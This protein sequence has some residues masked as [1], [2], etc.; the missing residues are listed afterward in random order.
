[1]K[2]RNV[3]ALAFLLAFTASM[4][5]QTLADYQFS[6]GHDASLWYTLTD[7]TDLLTNGNSVYSRSDLQSIGFDFPFADTSYSQFSVTHDGNLRLGS[8]LAISGSGNQASPFFAARAGNN[9]PKIN[10][11]G[12]AGYSSTGTHAYKQL[13]GTAPNRVMVVEFSL[14]TYTSSSRPALFVFQVQLHENG[15]IQV[16]YPSVAPSMMPSCNRQQGFCVDASDVWI[17]NQ[18]HEATHYTNGCSTY[19]GPGNWPDT[20]RYYRFEYPD[21]VCLSPSNLVAARVDTSSV[22]LAWNNPGFSTSFAVE[23]SAS[24]FA[25][26]TGAATMMVVNDT[27]AY[28]G[29]LQRDR[30]YHFYVRAICG[31]GDTSNAAYVLARTLQNVP[32]SDFP[33]YCDFED[34]EER[35]GWFTPAGNLATL[36][37]VDTAANNTAAGSY[38]LYISQDSGHTNTGGSQWIGAYAWRDV[39][40][41]AGD[42]MVGFDWRAAG[43]METSS[44]GNVNYYHF[45]RA[46]LVP[47]TVNFTIQTPASFPT[48][49][50]SSAVPAGWIELVPNH[51]LLGQTSWTRH[52]AAVNVPYAGCYHLTFYWETDGYPP[53]TDLP[54]AVDNIEM[55]YLSC[56]KPQGLT[57]TATEDEMMLRWQRV[58]SET[59][60][61]VRY[62]SNEVYVQD[63]FYLVTDLE[64]NTPYDFQVYTVCGEGD[65][66]QAATGTFR[67]ALGA[68][69]TQYPYVC[70]FEDSV[71]C[72]HWVMLDEGQQNQ[73]YCGTAAN[74]TLQGQR[75]IYVSNDGGTSNSYSGTSY[76]TSYA[77]REILLDV[78]TYVCSFDWRC[79]GDGEFHFLRAF[80]VPATSLP[81]SGSF[82]VSNNNYTAVPSGWTDLNPASHYMSEQSSWTTLTQSFDIAD[83]GLY[84]LLLMWFND[85]YT[86]HDPPAAVDN[87]MIDRITCPIP[88]NLSADAMQTAVDLTWDAGDDA[89]IWLVEYADTAL[90]TYT[91]SYTALGLSP[92]TEYTFSVSKLCMSGDTSLAATLTVRTKCEPMAMLPYF[93]D[94]EGY[95]VGTGSGDAFI[96]CWNRLC[97]YNSFS[98]RVDDGFTPGN[99]CL[100]FN[101]TVGLLDDVYVTLPELDESVEVTYTELSFKA[102]MFDYFGLYG[103]PVLIV[104]VMGDPMVASSFTPVD[105][106]VVGSDTGY[107]EYS[108]PMLSYVGSDQYV[109]IRATVWDEPNTPAV[110]LIDDV[111]LHELQYCRKPTAMTAL[112]GVDTIALSWT[113]G[114]D[115]TEWMVSYGDTM[116]T[117]QTSSYVARNLEADREYLFTV[118]AICSF[119]DTSDAITGH[120]RTL[121]RPQDPPDTVECLVPSGVGYYQETPWAYHSYEFHFYWSGDA[122]AYEVAIN[123]LNLPTDNELRFVVSDTTFF[124]DAHGRGAN[125][126]M[127]VRSLCS[128]AV[129]SGWSDTVEFDTPLCVR[130]ETP[131]TESGIA[132]YPNPSKGRSTLLLSGMEGMVDVRVVDLNGRLKGQYS[133]DCSSQSTRALLLD[134][135]ATGTYFVRI[136]GLDA[137]VVRKLVVR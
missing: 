91:P 69:V 34:G 71:E 125:W 99:H 28:I 32:V 39:N 55:E 113:A 72:R 87:I 52:Q 111:E 40:L 80:V 75:S 27:T 1:M 16:V 131:G 73:W 14:K 42:W 78:G 137:I 66:S 41:E 36:W 127:T 33:Y 93:D 30:Q 59:L 83:S 31:V 112:T 135:L 3:T 53:V 51:V 8:A 25:P 29:G 77:Y 62:G 122:P 48:S 85:N 38:A 102:R 11:F 12:C 128:D 103:E 22:T 92:N 37:Y 124:F 70:D 54:A 100:Y 45:L 18:N 2:T 4:H 132:L 19:I 64:F 43:D 97:N 123:C 49:P 46:F 86:P 114:G 60:W 7:S 126:T 129:S 115:E 117:T 95:A 17:V 90:M 50:H 79:Q 119:G 5:C 10:F 105:T 96:P 136:A 104:G 47:A 110:C 118:A 57:A 120:F 35:Q 121:P 88:A 134:G 89:Q 108:V 74:N 6:T 116:L 9:N 24:Q 106:I 21:G 67:T 133:V 26:G 44:T 61:M 107:V 23:Y 130:V 101:L 56:P 13:F 68:P 81:V 20:N 84:A 65:T 94:F 63:T 82:P 109:A 98:P 76:S 15:D 58:G